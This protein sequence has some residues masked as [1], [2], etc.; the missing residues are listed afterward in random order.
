MTMKNITVYFNEHDLDR[1]K[2]RVENKEFA[3]RSDAIRYMVKSW[4]D[5][6]DHGLI[7]TQLAEIVRNN[8]ENHGIDLG[9]L[10][11]K[12]LEQARYAIS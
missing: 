11:E 6:R 9:V 7:L 2:Q 1:I 8:D 12:V 5:I 3:D 4:L 10:F